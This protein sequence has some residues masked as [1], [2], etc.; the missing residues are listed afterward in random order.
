MMKSDS[1][2]HS[3]DCTRDFFKQTKCYI[4]GGLHYQGCITGLSMF[5]F[6]D[7]LPEAYFPNM[8]HLQILQILYCIHIYLGTYTT[9]K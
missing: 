7:I 9:F 6:R 4:F 1:W 8:L 3:R 5:Q 2:R